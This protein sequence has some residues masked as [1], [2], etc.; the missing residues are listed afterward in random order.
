MYTYKVDHIPRNT[1]N[2]RRPCI[3]MDP[4]YITIHSTAN[5]ASAKNER[6]YLT[7]PSNNR[8]ASYHIVIDEKEAI[9][10]L[11]LN[12]VGWHAGD[13]S[14][15]TGNRKSIGIEISEGGNRAETIKNAVS[16]VAK[17]LHERKWGVD[18]LRRHYDWSKKVCPRIMSNN[19]W[20]GWEDF[21]TSVQKELYAL[22]KPANL[23][24]V[25]YKGKV[26]ELEGFM[27]DGSNYTKIRDVLELTG[28]RVGWD[29]VAGV[30]LIDG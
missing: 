20:Q 2:N 28:H 5:T 24:K 19:S 18:K 7:N 25:K 16:L 4:E 30:V 21:K 9:E 29:N 13:G 10:C 11:P 1:P 12:E 22:S 17:M 6:A 15:G 27:K 3:Y 8:T 26:Y 14:K 23:V